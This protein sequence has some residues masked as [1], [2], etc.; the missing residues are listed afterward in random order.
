MNKAARIL[1]FC[2]GLGLI[3][4]HAVWYG[5]TGLFIA[6]LPL[7]ACLGIAATGRRLGLALAGFLAFAYLA[8][9]LTELTANP[10]ARGF[11]GIELAL[12]LVLL[13]TSVAALRSEKVR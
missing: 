8:H 5:M 4:L 2:A 9:G 1:L 13:V 12:S 11:A 10:A 6:G 7:A 3:G